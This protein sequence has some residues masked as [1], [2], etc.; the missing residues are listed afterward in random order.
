MQAKQAQGHETRVETAGYALLA[1]T[2][3]MFDRQFP[4]ANKFVVDAWIPRVRLVVQFD[5]DYWHGNPAWFTPDDLDH[6]QK[7]R[8]RLDISQDAYIRRCG[9]RVLRMWGSSLLH[10]V[11][12]CREVLQL[13]LAEFP[14]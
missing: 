3:I 11:A 12:S 7:K 1:E 6:R 10:D 8:M 13:A 2:G 5:G 14:P 4:Y 9:D